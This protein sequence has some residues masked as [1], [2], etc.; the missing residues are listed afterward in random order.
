MI[1]ASA[2]QKDA[3]DVFQTAPDTKRLLMPVNPRG[4][5]VC[6]D[7][8]VPIR[9]LRRIRHVNDTLAQPTWIIPRTTA[10]TAAIGWGNP[11]KKKSC[12][13]GISSASVSDM[14]HAIAFD[15]NHTKNLPPCDWRVHPDPNRNQDSR[16]RGSLPGGPVCDPPV[17]QLAGPNCRPGG[18]SG[19]KSLATV[20]SHSAD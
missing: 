16:V 15:S 6:A 4:L 19:T 11:P 8:V 13:R 10:D 17:S 1:A 2:R 5:D 3:H 18:A 12:S 7:D 14:A 20:A 9:L